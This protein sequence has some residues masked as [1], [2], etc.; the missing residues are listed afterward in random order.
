MPG[1]LNIV[2]S[3]SLIRLLN[4]TF[5]VIIDRRPNILDII[6]GGSGIVYVALVNGCRC[7]LIR[8]AFELIDGHEN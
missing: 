7:Q 2:N 4:G 6:G 1:I 8:E 5:G 3:G